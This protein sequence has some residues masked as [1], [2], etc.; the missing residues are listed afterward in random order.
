MK[1]FLIVTV[2]LIGGKSGS[3]A[4]ILRPLNALQS[5][6]A[7]I[8]KHEITRIAVQSDRIKGVFG[9]P[10]AY[11]LEADEDQGEIFIHPHYDKPFPLTITTEKGITQDLRLIPQDGSSESLILTQD[12]SLAP[13]RGTKI[14]LHR[15]EVEAL[16][17]ACKNNRIPVGYKEIPIEITALPHPYLLV[18]E[19]RNDHL[20]G[21]TFEVTTA[22]TEDEF[23]KT[24]GLPPQ[25]IVAILMPF[26][27]FT[28]GHVYVVTRTNP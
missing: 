19:I 25:D 17:E 14:L 5:I 8:S 28:G 10:D 16:L 7:S 6:E 2:V 22:M 9:S 21:L 12:H 4:A 3:Q 13:R 24:C 26:H 15:T 18:R 27:P 23:A 11:S 1:V 20:R